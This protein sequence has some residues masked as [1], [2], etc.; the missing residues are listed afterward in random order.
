MDTIES[1]TQPFHASSNYVESQLHNENVG[2]I[3]VKDFLDDSI[4]YWEDLSFGV[5]GPN[6]NEIA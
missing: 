2:P 4:D 5:F 3:E 1:D 6:E